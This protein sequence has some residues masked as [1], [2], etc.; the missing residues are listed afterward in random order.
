MKRYTMNKRNILVWALL[1]GGV[2][3]ASAQTIIRPKISCPNG[4]YVNSYNG[5][6]FYQRVDLQIPNRGLDLEAVFYYNSTSNR[7]NYAYGN[8]WRLGV[9]MRYVPDSAGIIIELGS[10]RQDLYI[11]YGTELRPPV[12]VLSTLTVVDEGYGLRT[13]EGTR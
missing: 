13:T 8:G 11:R 9:P 6:L 4:I 1:I 10:G 2:I 5:D 12:G 3:V 7:I